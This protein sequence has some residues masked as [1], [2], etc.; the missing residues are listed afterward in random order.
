MS[1]L[2]VSVALGVFVLGAGAGVA[3]WRTLRTRGPQPPSPISIV[4][5]TAHPDRAGARLPQNAGDA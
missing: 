1:L 5:P 2:V 4:P 3:G